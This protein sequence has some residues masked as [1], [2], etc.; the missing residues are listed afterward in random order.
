MA[1]SDKLASFVAS[2]FRSVWALELLLLL[3]AQRRPCATEELIRLLRAS[4]QV[5]ESALQSLVAAGLADSDGTA[6]SYMPIN[7]ELDALVD[8]TEQLYRSHPDRV[9]RLII[10]SAHKGLTAFSDA[11]RFKD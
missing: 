5:V 8:E 3:K 10:A 1:S 2:S 9:R 4:G 7:P 6:A 11:F